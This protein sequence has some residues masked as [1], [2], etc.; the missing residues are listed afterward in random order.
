MDRGRKSDSKRGGRI[1]FGEKRR[2]P[3][4]EWSRGG[5][6]GYSKTKKRYTGR[7]D[8]RDYDYQYIHKDRK[9]YSREELLRLAP[10]ATIK[11]DLL[12][13]LIT[14]YD[15]VFTEELKKPIGDTQE[16]KEDRFVESA[17]DNERGYD[18]RD[19]YDHSTRD[20]NS[21]RKDFVRFEG[22]EDDEAELLKPAAKNDKKGAHGR[23]KNENE[24]IPA[25]GDEEFDSLP[26]WAEPADLDF[27]GHK[28]S[29]D[30]SNY[31]K[32]NDNRGRN[33]KITYDDESEEEDYEDFDQELERRFKDRKSNFIDDFEDDEEYLPKQKP[34]ADLRR[35]SGASN[36]SGSIPA[37]KVQ[38]IT[39]IWKQLKQEEEEETEKKKAY[40]EELISANFYEEELRERRREMA[41]QNNQK[42]DFSKK[43]NKQATFVHGV[44]TV[45]MSEPIH[46]STNSGILG[47]FADGKGSTHKSDDSFQTVSQQVTRPRPGEDP[48]I[49]SSR[50]PAEDKEQLDLILGPPPSVVQDS[51]ELDEKTEK[52][53]RDFQEK[54]AVIDKA[55]ATLVYEMLNSKMRPTIDTCSVNGINQNSV[56]KY[57]AN[58]YKIFS[59]LMQCTIFARVWYYKDKVGNIQGPYMSFDMDIWNGEGKYFAKNLA[60]SPNK[61]DYFPL[62]KYLDRDQTIVDLMQQV[63]ED[64][65][66][67]VD[68]QPENIIKMFHPYPGWYPPHLMPTQMTGLP[69]PK[70]GQMPGALPLPNQGHGRRRNPAPQDLP[71]PRKV[72]DFSYQPQ[73]Q[74][75][76]RGD[77]ASSLLDPAIQFEALARGALAHN[78]NLE[79]DE[80]AFNRFVN[81]A[82]QRPD[83]KHSQASH[84]QAPSKPK[85]TVKDKLLDEKEFPTLEESFK[86]KKR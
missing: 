56:E 86:T 52:D 71:L 35:Q 80:I 77:A 38:D 1:N 7:Y 17:G 85:P 13:Q 69:F 23:D 48:A 58:R 66:K 41:M 51:R 42:N 75:P 61:K 54:Y 2:K 26:E 12:D 57:C 15:L 73:Q 10:N 31:A 21:K 37:D 67:G 39:S 6:T 79:G 19:D 40:Q 34:S 16:S 8:S 33:Q 84:K 60:I 29:K 28:G 32:Q 27:K 25:W 53:R 50:H 83:P 62:S 64:D 47:M 49:V 3:E 20:K 72:A 76:K 81:L 63:I 74:P 18:K 43:D 46:F 14:K 65:E 36:D 45:G 11:R 30:S 59:F 5:S 44:Q 68:Q 78:P 9:Q 55:L 24:D 4:E 82:G 22:F 70:P